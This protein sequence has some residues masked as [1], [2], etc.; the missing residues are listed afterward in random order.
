M[1]GNH[2]KLLKDIV[3]LTTKYDRMPG[4]LNRHIDN[5]IEDAMKL[6]L[7][8]RLN[9]LTDTVGEHQRL[10]CNYQEQFSDLDK[11]LKKYVEG[12]VVWT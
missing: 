9:E 5:R 1:E 2:Q 3:S 7:S 8:C 4:E 10:F 11:G 6:S 12:K